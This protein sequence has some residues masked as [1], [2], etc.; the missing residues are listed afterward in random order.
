MLPLCSL[1]DVSRLPSW[2]GGHLLT[3]VACS[4][5]ASTFS[6]GESW[7]SG[8]RGPCHPHCGKLTLGCRQEVSTLEGVNPAAL[9]PPYPLF[10]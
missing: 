9:P 8:P 3:G 1:A 10:M 7:I 2:E 5:D 4:T 6:E